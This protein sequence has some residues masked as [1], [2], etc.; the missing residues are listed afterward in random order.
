MFRG[1]NFGSLLV[2]FL[3]VLLVFGT[4]RLRTIGGDLGAALKS[5]RD[6]LKANE[7]DQP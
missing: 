7:T 2:I 4:K 5:F 6:G 3:I 1:L